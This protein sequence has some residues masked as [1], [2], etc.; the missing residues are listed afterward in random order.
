MTA[1]KHFYFRKC[2]ISDCGEKSFQA[3]IE[4]LITFGDNNSSKNPTLAKMW[5]NSYPFIS[6][7]YE[8][9]H[10]LEYT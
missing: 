8:Y 10:Y 7:K 1:I 3:F 4:I 2:N 6:N 9:K 5:A